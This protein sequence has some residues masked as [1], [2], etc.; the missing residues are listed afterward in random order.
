MIINHELVREKA[1]L[2]ESCAV[3][4]SGHK[5]SMFF[6][7]VCVYVGP[8]VAPIVLWLIPAISDRPV[9]LDLV[10]KMNCDGQLQSLRLL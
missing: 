8:L 4:V 3:S 2:C 7:D 6:F 9:W 10:L 1:C 5:A